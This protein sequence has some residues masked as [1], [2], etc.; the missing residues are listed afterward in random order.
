MA[1]VI[2]ENMAAFNAAYLQSNICDKITG[3]MEK[4]SL[5]K[6]Q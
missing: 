6:P 1:S 2:R 3:I 5:T 4:I